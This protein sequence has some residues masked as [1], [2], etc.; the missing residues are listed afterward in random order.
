MKAKQKTIGLIGGMSWESTVTYYQIINETIKQELG[1]LHSAKILLYSVDFDEI[2]HYQSIGAWQKSAEILAKI[3]LTLEKAGANFIVICT[4]TMHKVAPYIKQKISIPLLHIAE[5]TAETLKEQQIQKVGLLGTQY[6][7]TQDFYKN[8]LIEQGIE[9]VIP[10][11]VDIFYT[12]N[13]IYEEL[14]RGIILSSSKE[15]YLK[16]ISKLQQNGVEAIILG[17]TEIGLLIKQEDVSL[18]IFDTALIHARKAALKS[19]DK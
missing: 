17:C 18:P 5:A 7:L 2:E 19:I 9:V 3:A 15:M 1:G 8:I 16:V 10:N 13:I 6:T 14:C 12:N 4:N 11:K